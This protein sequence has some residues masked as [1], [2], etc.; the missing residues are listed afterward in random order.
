[1][2]F[3]Q[4]TFYDSM[5]KIYQFIFFRVLGW[6][7]KG[8]MH[9]EV[10]KC[11]IIVVPHTSWIDFAV[12]VFTRGTIGLQMNFVAKKELFR[13]PFGAYFRWM[14]GAPLNRQKNENKVDAIA[15]IFKQREVFRLAIAPEGTRKKV[16]EWKT[17]FY[18]IALK[19]NVPIVAV[20][21]DY[22][23]KTVKIAEPYY[24]IGN[25]TEDIKALELNYKGVVG[26]VPEFSYK[27]D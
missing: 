13:F 6:Q 2:L 15:T 21:F 5:K 17:G 24:L 23:T 27:N 22:A 26:L 11:V 20:A 8:S 1:M 25:K 19:A 4:L 18:Y 3:L 7:I 12:G 16:S 14:G 10:K 9:P